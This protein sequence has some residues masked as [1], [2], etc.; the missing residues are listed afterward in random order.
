MATV[1]PRAK[2]RRLS[3]QGA[4][5]NYSRNSGVYEPSLGTSLNHPS[6]NVVQEMIDGQE[7]QVVVVSDDEDTDAPPT[8]PLGH[9]LASTNKDA[10]PCPG[11][12]RKASSPSI[13]ED[14]SAKRQ[15]H[16]ANLAILEQ[17]ASTLHSQGMQPESNALLY[18]DGPYAP[19]QVSRAAHPGAP[20][21]PYGM[22]SD[23]ASFFHHQQT[24]A[25]PYVN[26]TFSSVPLTDWNSH[27]GIGA[28]GITAMPNSMLM[29]RAQKQQ[30]NLTTYRPSAARL[31]PY[32]EQF[33]EAWQ[34]QQPVREP[35]VPEAI[36]DKDGHIVVREGDMISA[37]YQIYGML[38][39]GTFGKVVHCYDRQLRRSVAIKVIRAIQKYRDASQIEIRVLRCLRQNDASNEYR[40]IQLL[41]TFDFRNHVCIVSDLLDRSV[42]DFLKDN[43]FQPFPCRHIWSFAKQ[44]CKSVAFLHRLTLIH[45]DLKPEN[46][47]L[48]DASFDVVATSRS[49]NARKRRVLRNDEI[50][51]ID[52]GSATFNDEYHSGV[53]STRHYRAP[54]IILGMGWSYPCDAWSLGCILVEFFTGDALFQTHDNLEHLAMMESVLG[55]LPDDYRRKAETYKPEFFRNGRLDYPRSDTSKQS[56]RYVQNMKPLH[57]IVSPHASFTKHN[58]RFIS[59][60]RGLLEFDPAKRITLQEALRHPYFDL[61]PNEIPP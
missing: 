59:L 51:L 55:I 15:R 28:N 40:C 29:D 30:Q 23:Y 6:M 34:P 20:S 2:K 14:N 39:Q 38:G 52:F 43:S 49:A 27:T 58:Q 54:E 50:R 53:V 36:D 24:D 3:P 46:I 31:Q 45:T 10:L 33:T 4:Y 35:P 13:P 57:Q 16:E 18:T 25:S 8:V 5:G 19:A 48:I 12:K 32:Q 7:R 47:L 41:D 26:N 1:V 60:L 44:L 22:P 42:F 11:T 37:R 56:R 61:A 9:S 21:S 17:L